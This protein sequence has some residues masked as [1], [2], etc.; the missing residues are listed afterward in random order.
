M[1]VV[2]SVVSLL[3]GCLASGATLEKLS[4]DD[5]SRKSTL[6]VRGRIGACAGEQRGS[7]IY[8]RCKVSVIERWKGTAG[9]QVDLLIPGGTARGLIQMFTGT[10]KLRNGAEYVLFLWSGK[11][12]VLQVIGLSQGVFDVKVDGKGGVTAKREATA[13]VMLDSAGQTV[14]DEGVQMTVAALRNRVALTLE[15]A[16]GDTSK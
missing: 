16:L 15:G 2:F 12:G 8:T 7:V 11:S 3:C 13:E 14:H 6:I 10:P 1:R 5:M 9:N 4:I